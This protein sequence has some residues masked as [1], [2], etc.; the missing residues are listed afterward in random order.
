VR[1]LET[2]VEQ[3]KAV[4]QRERS[5]PGPTRPQA[6]V[7]QRVI[8]HAAADPDDRSRVDVV[9]AHQLFDRER[10]VASLV[11]EVFCQVFLSGEVKSV[12]LPAAPVQLVSS[13]PDEIERR[14]ELV[15][16]LRIDEAVQQ[17]V[18]WPANFRLDRPRGP[19]RGVVVAQGTHTLPQVRLQKVDGLSKILVAL[20]HLVELAVDELAGVLLEVGSNLPIQLR[21]QCRI[22][23]QKARVEIGRQGRQVFTAHSQAVVNRASRHAHGKPWIRPE[24]VSYGLGKGLDVRIDLS[25]VEEEEIDIGAE[26][27]LAPAVPTHRDYREAEVQTREVVKVSVLG[28]AEQLPH[29]AIDEVGM[30]LIYA[31]RW[32]AIVVKLDQVSP[33]RIEVGSHERIQV[34]RCRSRARGLRL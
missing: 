15:K 16:F 25:A 18:L 30:L 19:Q 33:H 32:C 29:E 2:T 14:E 31:P 8:N 26:R 23:D 1:D 7:A 11:T 10:A 3:R 17:Q 9:G 27:E 20:P 22:P 13:P 24:A 5:V 34:E 28:E 4:G 12:V 21:G 6:L